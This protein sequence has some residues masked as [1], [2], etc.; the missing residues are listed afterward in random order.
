MLLSSIPLPKKKEKKKNPITIAAQERRDS[1]AAVLDASWGEK[2]RGVR[3]EMR[4]RRCSLSS[5]L[6]FG[7]NMAFFL[8]LGTM[9]LNVPSRLPSPPH[10]GLP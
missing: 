3:E 7:A 2:S 1:A 6:V 9:P 5:S 4:V 8:L 10:L